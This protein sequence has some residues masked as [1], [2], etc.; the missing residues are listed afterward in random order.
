[1]FG[2]VTDTSDLLSQTAHQ[3]YINYWTCKT[4]ALRD[5]SNH[6]TD[7]MVSHPCL[8]QPLC[9]AGA[10]GLQIGQ[11][12]C[13]VFHLA[14]LFGHCLCGHT[15]SLMFSSCYHARHTQSMHEGEMKTIDAM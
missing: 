11:L 14:H 12:T 8:L 6:I 1:M 4:K 10:L 15:Y 7:S 3:T 13:L 9:Q 5:A 2:D